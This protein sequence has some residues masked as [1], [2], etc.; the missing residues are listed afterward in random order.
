MLCFETKCHFI[1][2]EQRIQLEG[3]IYILCGGVFW[4]SENN[5]I[6]SDLN[7][8]VFGF[9]SRKAVVH[10]LWICPVSDNRGSTESFETATGNTSYFAMGNNFPHGSIKYPDSDHVS[11]LNLSQYFPPNTQILANVFFLPTLH[12]HCTVD[13][14]QLELKI[15]E[16][17]TK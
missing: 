14:H 9:I 1:K 5:I 10:G 11:L 17:A 16:R 7:I 6:F 2:H 8:L 4:T 13:D 3:N 12:Q 15:S